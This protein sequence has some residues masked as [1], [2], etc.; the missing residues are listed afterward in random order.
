MLVPKC[1]YKIFLHFIA[2]AHSK[3]VKR[4]VVNDSEE[5]TTATTTLTLKQIADW[6]YGVQPIGQVISISETPSTESTITEINDET[7]ETPAAI[8]GNL[9]L[10]TYIILNLHTNILDKS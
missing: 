1:S 3:K 9:P 8:T 4:S 5:F 7:D 2:G 10:H 6:F